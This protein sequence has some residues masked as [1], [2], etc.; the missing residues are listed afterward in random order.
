MK[1][2]QLTYLENLQDDNY[3]N[4]F[5]MYI[6]E[7]GNYFYNINKGISIDG[8]DEMPPAFYLNYEVQYRDTWPLIAY[9]VYDTKELWWL[10]CKTLGIKNPTIAPVPGEI[11]P[12]L[13]PGIVSSIL[14][15]IEE[16]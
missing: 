4:L 13:Q 11:I 6:D 2:N 15:G 8:V 10:V 5:N 12:V 16:G 3:A 1:Q 7:Y 14:R 9:K